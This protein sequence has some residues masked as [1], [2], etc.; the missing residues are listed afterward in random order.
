MHQFY[1]FIG[2]DIATVLVILENQAEMSGCMLR[3]VQ[4]NDHF[5]QDGENRI[6]IV[7]KNDTI[8]DIF[9]G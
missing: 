3:L 6:T 7:L 8:I 9:R 2:C 4:D 5:D 1:R